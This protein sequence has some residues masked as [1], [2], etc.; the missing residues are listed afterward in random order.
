MLALWGYFFN[1]QLFFI[2]ALFNIFYPLLLFPPPVLCFQSLKRGKNNP[3]KSKNI[4]FV[5]SFSDIER[6][7]GTY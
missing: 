4:F 3:P 2:W 5:A 6:R 7:E 1:L